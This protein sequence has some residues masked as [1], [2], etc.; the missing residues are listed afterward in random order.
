[1]IASVRSRCGFASTSGTGP[2]GWWSSASGSRASRPERFQ[3]DLFQP[4]DGYY[5]YSMV[6]TNKAESESYD[7]GLHGGARRSREDAGRAE[8]ER[9]LRQRGDGRLGCQQHLADPVRLDPQPHAPLPAPDRTR[10]ASPQ[11]TQANLPAP[12]RLDANA[13]VLGDP[14]ACSGRPAFWPLGTPNRGGPHRAQATSSPSSGPSLP[15]PGPASL[16]R[17]DLMTLWG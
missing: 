8:A 9:H 1:M 7:L 6:V 14:P 16:Q 3:L 12:L 2:S 13:A 4:D 10:N 15:D 5:E 17:V 11:R